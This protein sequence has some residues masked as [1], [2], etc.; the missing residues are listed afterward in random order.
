MNRLVIVS[1]LLFF[2]ITQIALFAGETDLYEVQVK[3]YPRVERGF[4]LLVDDE[5][6]GKIP[7]NLKLSEGMHSF[8]LEWYEEYKPVHKTYEVNITD[9]KTLIYLP[10]FVEKESSWFAKYGIWFVAGTGIGAIIFF[11]TMNAGF[12]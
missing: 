10:S 11:T 6:K 4:T 1:V 2:L 7:Q 9:S 3:L 5:K 8:T 12:G